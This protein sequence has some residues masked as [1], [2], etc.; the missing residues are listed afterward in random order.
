MPAAKEMSGTATMRGQFPTRPAEVIPPSRRE[1]VIF[2]LMAVVLVLPPWLIGAR[3]NWAQWV[4]LFLALLAFGAIFV[5]LADF[6]AW[7]PSPTARMGWNR[8]AK[9]PIFWIGL[10]ILIYGVLAALNPSR[11]LMIADQRE[12]LEPRPHTAW[13]PHSILTSFW[14]MNAWRALLIIV[15]AWL[16]TCAVWVG[17]ETEQAWHRLLAAA[18]VNGLLLALFGI[19]QRMANAPNMFWFYIPQSSSGDQ[20]FFGSF[21]YAGHAAAWMVLA[22]G[23]AAAM[24]DRHL[25][26]R[27]PAAPSAKWGWPEQT[28]WLWVGVLAAVVVALGVF[29]K[30]HFWL[31][32]LGGVMVI[33]AWL[34]LRR[35]WL[36]G[37]KRR[38]AL[39]ALPALVF[40][41]ILL[42]ATTGAAWW[43]HQG[44]AGAM[45]VNPHDASLPVRYAI[46]RTSAVM[47]KDEPWW[48][49]GPGSFRYVAPFYLRDNPLFADPNKSGDVRFTSSFAHSDW[50]QIPAEWGLV[51]AIMFAALPLWWVGQAWRLRHIL[52]GESRI[53]LGTV[54]LI[55]I[56]AA[57]DFPFYNPAVLIAVGVL[58]AAA[59][60][61]GEIAARPRPL[62]SKVRVV[63]P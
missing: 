44:G 52:P 24:M 26:Q 18:A 12:W 36:E 62:L 23:A 42:T 33:Y 31:L 3:E 16:A 51:G 28:A 27:D 34:W 30:P 54:A 37:Q 53:L 38:A 1:Q 9:F 32:A 29:V 63:C 57:A 17:L 2:I 46:A 39:Y 43:W 58:T 11:V 25:R 48:G 13:L 56:G 49:W 15:P 50:V 35:W 5:P 10:A 4:T 6:R 40:M 60:K 55:F 59:I 20:T 21:V 14:P 19:I 61:L 22:C 8:L 47:I 45:E 41:A 7:P